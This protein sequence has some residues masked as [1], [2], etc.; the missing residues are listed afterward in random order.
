MKR[1][2]LIYRTAVE[3]G[4][5]T[6]NHVLGC[7]HG[8]KYPC[9]AMMLKRRFGEIKDYNDWL[10]PRLVENYKEILE[11]EISRYKNRIKNLHLCFTTDPFMF[12]HDEVVNAS[13]DILHMLAE[14]GIQ[15]SVLTKSI[16]PESLY[17]LPKNYSFGITLISLDEKF[18]EIM[19]PGA[20]PYEDRIRSLKKM[21]EKGFKT[22]V[23]I[24][25]YPTPNIIK[26]DFTKILESIKFVDKI[27]F[28]KINYNKTAT[29]YKDKDKFFKSLVNDLIDFCKCNNIK[30]HIKEGT[31]NNLQK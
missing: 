11:R 31:L 17:D 14:H 28:G 15:A 20:A 4:D 2:T 6:L 9:Y 7:S 16:F 5:Y 13:I 18:R 19:E 10:K 30:Y 26:Q 23:S 24:E 25:P 22:W 3:Y 8:C 27:V 21:K 12:G 1:K 29:S